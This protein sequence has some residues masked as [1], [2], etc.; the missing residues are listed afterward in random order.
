ML[1]L[2]Q[3]LRECTKTVGDFMAVPEPPT[4]KL[5]QLIDQ[6]MHVSDDSAIDPS[7]S[8]PP[9]ERPMSNSYSD[10][11][12][13]EFARTLLDAMYGSGLFDWSEFV[14]ELHTRVNEDDAFFTP[15]QW[16]GTLRTA[17]SKEEFWE[18]FEADN[19]EC[20]AHALEQ[21]ELAGD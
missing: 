10:P 4:G 18:A 13:V 5:N 14:M 6:L 9:R 19:P 20:V 17:K 21:L 2:I 15:K 12:N 1:L 8:A 11:E 3:R 7:D 16:R